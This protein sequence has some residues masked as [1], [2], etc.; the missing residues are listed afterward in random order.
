LPD[1]MFRLS[2]EQVQTFLRHLWATDG[3][4]HVRPVGHKGSARV[5]FSTSSDGL[6]RDV[7]AL[8]LRLEIV[9][10]IRPVQQRTRRPLPTV[11]ISGGVAQKRFL[12]TVGAFG[13]RCGPARQLETHLAGHENGTNVDTLPRTVFEEV[14]AAMSARGVSQRAM[15]AMRGTSYGGTS[16]F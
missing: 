6:A 8:L 2:N 16:H 14:R 12:Q 5:F 10:R 9:A 13:P 7:A 4:I 11:D 1:A 3:S 15:T